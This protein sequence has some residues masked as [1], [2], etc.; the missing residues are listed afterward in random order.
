MQKYIQFS[1]AV[2]LEIGFFCQQ[3]TEQMGKV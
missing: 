1:I 2:C 3:T